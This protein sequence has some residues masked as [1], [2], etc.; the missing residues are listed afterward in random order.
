MGCDV[1]MFIEK[2]AAAGSPWEAATVRMK[3][4]WCPEPG[5]DHEKRVGEEKCYFC[6]GTKVLKTYDH[7]N[8][9]AFAVLAN[10]RNGTGF[11]GVVTGDVFVPLSEP[12]DLP[13]DLSLRLRRVF[14]MYE[15]PEP[16][17]LVP[18]GLTDEEKERFLE[19]AEKS[20][21]ELYDR[22]K[23]ELGEGGPGD[24]SFSH[25]T[26]RELLATDEY[27]NQEHVHTGV[28]GFSEILA[29]VR[30]GATEP[31]S[32]CGDVSGGSIRHYEAEFLFKAAQYLLAQEKTVAERGDPAALLEGPPEELREFLGM[33]SDTKHGVDVSPVA[34]AKRV[35]SKEK[36]CYVFDHAYCRL[37]WVKKYKDSVGALYTEFIPALLELARESG[38]T[39]D[40]VRIVFGFDS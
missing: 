17:F 25:L 9:D 34:L 13:E 10:V 38:V 4:D 35:A 12:R 30:D 14:S 32:W 31:S 5:S 27:W 7:R 26:L 24:H 6:K 37:A 21:D 18:A 40:D 36:G 22:N 20:R 23:A 2:R 29:M 1:H 3:C 28:V 33:P 11:A 16:E 8:Y 19:E 15:D 39:P